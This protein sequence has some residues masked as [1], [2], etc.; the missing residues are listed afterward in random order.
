MD[1]HLYLLSGGSPSGRTW[2]TKAPDTQGHRRDSLVSLDQ[3]PWSIYYSTFNLLCRHHPH[4]RAPT[5]SYESHMES[6]PRGKEWE[7]GPITR[8]EAKGTRR[9]IK[10]I[11]TLMG[12]N[13]GNCFCRKYLV[14]GPEPSPAISTSSS[15]SFS[16]SSYRAIL[17]G[18]RVGEEPRSD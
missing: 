15:P 11:R 4:T 6:P 10:C 17:H 14:N 3:S 18:H 1:S 13:S 7:G 9:R 12:H 8:G 5:R 16:S 2:R